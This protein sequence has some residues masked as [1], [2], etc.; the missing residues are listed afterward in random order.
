MKKYIFKPYSKRFPELFEREKERI[1]SH[2]KN[3]L[4][5]EHVGSTA[6]PHLGGKG[7]IDIA[8]GVEEIDSVSRQL[9]SLGYEFRPT[10]STPDRL[11]FRVDL[12]DPEEG[13]RRYHIHLMRLG[14]KDWKDLLSFRDYLRNH[15]EEAEKYADLKKKAAAEVNEDGVKYREVKDPMFKQILKKI[16]GKCS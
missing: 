3:R 2:V 8:I 11:F 10:R 4:I 12:P 16:E 14:N 13:A 7:I 15:P 6:V 1:I 5:I 9:Q